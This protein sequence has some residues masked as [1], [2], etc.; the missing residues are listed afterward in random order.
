MAAWVLIRW[1]QRAIAYRERARLKQALLYTRCRRVALAIGDELVRR[2]QL[3]HRDDV[4]MLTLQEID[5]LSAGRAMFPHGVAALVDAPCEQHEAHAALASARQLPAA[6]G[7][8]SSARRIASKPSARGVHPQT[9]DLLHGISACGGRVLGARGRP[10]RRQRGAPTS[11]R[12]RA[13]HA[14]DRSRL[15][16]GV[17]PGVGAGHR[18]RRH[19]V[20]RRHH[21]ARVRPAVRR[22][23]RRRDQPDSARRAGSPSTPTPARAASRRRHERARRLRRRAVPAAGVRACDWS[24]GDRGVGACHFPVALHA[25]AGR[26]PDAGAGRQ[27]RLWDDLEDRDADRAATSRPR[28]RHRSRDAVL[29]LAA[30]SRSRRDHARLRRRR[31]WPV[32]PRCTPACSGRIGS[33]RHL[34]DRVWRFG[35]LLLK[36]PAFV[37]IAALGSR[38][39]ADGR[40]RRRRRL[41]PMSARCV[42]EIRSDA[43][44]HVEVRSMTEHVACLTCGK[45]RLR[46]SSRPK[47]T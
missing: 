24:V 13:G 9:A 18:A 22:R 31:P 21:R 14:T 27:F 38:G 20:A 15:G 33:G 6:G 4:F 40:A 34:R 44:N 46:S 8:L 11:R 23:R 16:T 25:R 10:G 17:L 42:Y 19:A 5:E 12:R 32:W 26:R 43:A 36:Y 45:P 3:A 28:D 41:R 47:T 39:V 7:V 1:T 35:I 30:F 29:V 37:V 2:G